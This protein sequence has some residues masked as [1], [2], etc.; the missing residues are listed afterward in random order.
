MSSNWLGDF[1]PEQ[2]NV[3]DGHLRITA[4]GG[5]NG[6]ICVGQINTRDNWYFLYGYAEIRC[7]HPY[8]LGM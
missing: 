1:F 4:S 7:K 3:L 5:E 6:R 2:V 8:A